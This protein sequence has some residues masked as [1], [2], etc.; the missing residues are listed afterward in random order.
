MCVHVHACV[1]VCVCVRDDIL[2]HLAF[3][4]ADVIAVVA[5]A[6]NHIFQL[7]MCIVFVF[8]LQG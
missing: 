5:L 1:C 2:C 3:V 6:L 4:L 7:L 8:F